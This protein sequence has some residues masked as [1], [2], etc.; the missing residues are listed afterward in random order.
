MRDV[1]HLPNCFSIHLPLTF[2]ITVSSPTS[3]F[4][5]VLP[6]KTKIFQRST[7]P[8]GFKINEPSIIVQED[9]TTLMPPGCS[10]NVDQKLNLIIRTQ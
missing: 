6:N 4:I 8:P 9:A 1:L 10:L 5:A 3:E 2:E 7:L